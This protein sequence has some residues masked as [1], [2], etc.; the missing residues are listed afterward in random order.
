MESSGMLTV[1]RRL[2]ALHYSKFTYT[3]PIILLCWPRTSTSLIPSGRET[4][5]SLREVRLSNSK[6][7][8]IQRYLYI[9]PKVMTDKNQKEDGDD[10]SIVYDEEEHA[11]QRI[12]K[13]QKAEELTKR[14][15]SSDFS[16]EIIERYILYKDEHIVVAN[17]PSGVLCVPGV[18]DRKSLANVVFD[19][20][21]NDSNRVDRMIVHRLDMHTSGLVIFARSDDVQKRL[22]ELFR[23]RKVRKQYEALVCGNLASNQGEINLPL[24]RDYEF[25]PFMRVSTPASEE[26]TARAAETLEHRGW[27]K[28]MRKA[29]KDSLTT[30]EVVGREKYAGNTCTRIML[31]PV[32]GR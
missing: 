2:F 24:Q 5:A 11:Q 29:P 26:Y 30:F 18:H 25:P 3:L 16:E 12:L 28:M 21:G 23:D 15:I 13:K 22:H 14:G 20:Y 4:F 7:L 19:K 10:L 17:K 8:P 1:T 31:T 9:A 6:F 27:K 32:T